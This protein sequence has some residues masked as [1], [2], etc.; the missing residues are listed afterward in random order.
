[1]R[2]KERGIMNVNTVTRIK[3]LVIVALAAVFAALLFAGP[4]AGHVIDTQ[5]GHIQVQTVASGLEHPWGL[6]F[7]PDGHML[8]TE[9]PGR[10]RIVSKEG[11]LSEPLAGI[12]RV[13]AEGQGGLLDVAL[14]PNFVSNRLIYLSYAE[15]G[16]G[17]ASTAVARAQLGDGA[18]RDIQVIFRQQPK[19]SG[20][21]HFGSRLVFSPDGKLF[22]TLGERFKFEPAQDLSNHLGKIV[23]I[24]PDG[25]VPRD[26]PFVGRAGAKPEIWSYGHRNIQGAAIHPGSGALWV[27]EFGPRGGDE[28]NIPEPGRN[29]GWPLVSWGRH[30]FG[31]D[32]PDPPT[33]PDLAQSIYHWTPVISPSGM[34]FYTGEVFPAW[35]GNL[36]IGGLSSQALVRLVLDGQ[37]VTGEE[38]IPMDVRIRDVRQGPDGAVYL[39]TDQSNGEILRLTPAGTGRD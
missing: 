30:Y 18:L 12:P 14:D 1:M 11:R 28:L 37:R 13:L 7:L 24:N 25:S 15:P 8:V 31:K 4:R 3:L 16:E 34:T 5:V 22:V 2:F 39:L 19:V 35:R 32:I 36:L 21:N 17:G 33:R 23:R 29:Y 10:L 27:N 38:C 26:N 6:A 20:P 9:R